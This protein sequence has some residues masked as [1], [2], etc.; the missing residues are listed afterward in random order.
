MQR[1]RKYR[2]ILPSPPPTTNENLANEDGEAL[3]GNPNG[4]EGSKR[5]RQATTR[6]CNSC[7]EKKIGVIPHASTLFDTPGSFFG[8]GAFVRYGLGVVGC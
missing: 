4:Q 5:K 7:H 8:S 1:E 6:A 2:N 3:S